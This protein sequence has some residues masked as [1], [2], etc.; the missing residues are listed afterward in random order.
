MGLRTVYCV[1]SFARKAGALWAKPI[2]QFG[3]RAEA[4]AVG[5]EMRGHVIGAIVFSIEGCPTTGYWSE[6]T[7][8]ARL[9][10]APCRIES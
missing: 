10:T 8:L 9:G 7:V 3:S 5:G 6:P 1:Q 2:R 4:M